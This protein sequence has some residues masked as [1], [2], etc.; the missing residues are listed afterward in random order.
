MR[1]L[2]DPLRD[3]IIDLM[4]GA[5]RDEAP[6]DLDQAALMVDQLVVIGRG[7]HPLASRRDV[8]LDALAEMPWIVGQRGTPLRH[9]WEAMF[10][11][12]D[13]P[14]APIECGSVMTV[15]GVLCESDFLTLLSPDQVAM[16]IDAGLLTII[17]HRLT[18]GS[19]TIGITTRTGWRATA[20][21]ARFVSLVEQ[22]AGDTRLSKN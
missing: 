15:R 3:G 21:Q 16:E 11:A 17:D 13:P 10:A 1:E 20:A 9:H 14:A 5:L 12:M 2:V 18:G 4:I 6:A 7:G 19:R 22:A 8:A